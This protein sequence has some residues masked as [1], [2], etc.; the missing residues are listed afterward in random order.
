MIV[1]AFIV[2][3]VSEIIRELQS[4]NHLRKPRR[5][6]P[7]FNSTQKHVV[8]MASRI[9]RRFLSTTARRFQE[10]QKAELKKES[11]RNPEILILGGV[12]VAA[13]GG[14]G[15]YL[16]RSPTGAT[17]ESPVTIATHPWESGSS[18]KYQ[19]HPGGDPNAAPKDAPSA[20]NVVVVPNVTLPAELHEKYNKWGKDGYP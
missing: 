13:L 16:G 7:F 14:A 4:F 3:T 18:G 1:H 15:Y 11:R 5:R 6:N 19:Y 2:A 17:S 20:L 12:M 10:H 9:S 8:K